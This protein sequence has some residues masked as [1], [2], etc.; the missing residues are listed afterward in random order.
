MCHAV[1]YKRF[2]S[3][4]NNSLVELAL[5]L[6]N[7]FPS[8]NS[9]SDTMRLFTIVEGKGKLIYHKIEYILDHMRWCMWEKLTPWKEGESWRFISNRQIMLK[10]LTS[11]TSTQEKGYAVIFGKTTHRHRCDQA[12]GRISWWGEPTYDGK[13]TPSFWMVA[14]TQD[15][16]QLI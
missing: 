6:I 11:F 10:E 8:K 12:S 2:I 3:L 15:W 16:W 14:R 5:N 13:Q 4:V 9:I 7:P 1:P